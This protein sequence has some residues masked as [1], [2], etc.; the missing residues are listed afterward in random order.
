[1]R[2]FVLWHAQVSKVARLFGR[3]L[4][5]VDAA[6]EVV[7]QHLLATCLGLGLGS[8]LGLGFRFGFGFGTVR[9]T[10][11]VRARLRVIGY[12]RFS[13]TVR[14]RVRVSYRSSGSRGAWLG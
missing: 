11:R 1:M 2:L 6:K 8:G 10:V 12:V 14:V 9:V 13:A 5:P 4:V 7:L 3:K